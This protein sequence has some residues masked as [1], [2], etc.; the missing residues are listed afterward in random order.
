MLP[1]LMNQL[2]QLRLSAMAHALETQ[3][4]QPQT[5]TELGFEERL[6]LLI[7]QE[8]TEREQRKL[9]RLLNR[10]KLKLPARFEDIEYP[11]SRGLSKSQ[12]ASLQTGDW[13]A[14]HQNLLLAGPTG[15]GKSFIA[16]A[17]GDRAC[18][19]GYSVR[20][21]RTSRLLEA[22]TLAHGDGSFGK[23]LRQ[24]KQIDVL[25]LDDW[26]LDQITPSQRHDLLELM[27]DRH[28]FSST[29]VASQLPIT[30]WHNTLGDAT[31]AD[32]ILDRLIHNAH[33][34]TLKGDSMRKRL[35]PEQQT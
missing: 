17:L 1:T 22:L 8:L 27:D 5:Y 23:L 6:H 33:R 19:Q 11:A 13:I 16:C 2:K 26:G 35:Q 32:A 28:G 24:L 34:I 9:R 12:M 31:L 10:A 29:V 20:Y 4:A 14:R 7:E 25:L 21:Y 15:C 18:H 3:V 30:Q